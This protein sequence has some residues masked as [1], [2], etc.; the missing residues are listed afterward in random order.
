MGRGQALHVALAHGSLLKAHRGL[1]GWL[2]GS[3]GRGHGLG[4]T[5]GRAAP[6]AHG[7]WVG[8]IC[9]FTAISRGAGEAARLPF[10]K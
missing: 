5:W 2:A 8:V 4:G 1:S 3:S 6:G 9:G 7:P 10:T